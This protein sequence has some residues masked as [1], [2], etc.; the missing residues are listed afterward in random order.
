[1]NVSALT[2]GKVILYL[3]AMF[4]V[5][6]GAGTVAGYS[7]AKQRKPFGPPPSRADMA[8]HLR[9]KFQRELELTPDQLAKLDPLLAQTFREVEEAGRRNMRETGK[10]FERLNEQISEFL[11]PKQQ[12]ALVEMDRKRQE[13]MRK[14]PRGSTNRPPSKNSSPG[15]GPDSGQGAQ[16]PPP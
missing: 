9:A 4:V 7:L 16:T 3:A 12:Q 6:A 11:T 1:M 10:L 8:T 14:H 15:P 13:W 5:A 2:K